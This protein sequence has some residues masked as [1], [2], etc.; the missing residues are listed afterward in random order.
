LAVGHLLYSFLSKK[1]LCA[2]TE[3]KYKFTR[4]TLFKLFFVKFPDFLK[5]L[6]AVLLKLKIENICYFEI[7]NPEIPPSALG[8]KFC[9]LDINM[10]VDDRLIDIEVQVSDEGDYPE[11]SLYDWARDFSSA[12]PTSGKYRELPET[13]VISIIAF[14]MFKDYTG[15]HSEFR[16]LEVTRHTALTPKMCL[17]YFELPKLP[18]ITDGDDALKLWLALFQAKTEEDLS[19]ITQIGGIVMEQVVEAYRSVSVSDELKEI[20]RLREL[21]RYNEAS[22]IDY[23]VR[24]AVREDRAEM[25]K[26]LKSN[27]VD[28]NTIAK[29]TGLSVEEIK[30]L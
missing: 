9:R 8:E 1:E 6:V 20:E 15:F 2:V 16:P 25:A 30:G 21:A 5:M 24:K 7:K 22:A 28:V 26:N 14:N 12:L 3:L 18:E 11:R 23:A 19:K 17:H 29:S 10:K 27:G 13:I 4:D